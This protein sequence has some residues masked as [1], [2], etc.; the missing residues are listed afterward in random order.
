MD[1]VSGETVCVAVADGEAGRVCKLL[2]TKV[3]VR[4]VILIHFA[5]IQEVSRGIIIQ[6]AFVHDY[7]MVRQLCMTVT[8]I[9]IASMKCC[10][11]KVY[12]V[13]LISS[14]K[15]LTL[16]DSDFGGFHPPK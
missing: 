7:Y 2:V 13:F 8:D 4:D 16:L 1:V 15:P 3:D 10:D 12:D 9:I 6:I 5:C 11:A 14:Q